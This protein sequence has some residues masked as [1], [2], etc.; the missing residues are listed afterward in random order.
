MFLYNRCF[1]D[2]AFFKK[3]LGDV[4]VVLRSIIVDVFI[5][6]VHRSPLSLSV[7]LEHSVTLLHLIFFSLA[8]SSFVFSREVSYKLCKSGS[9]AH[10]HPSAERRQRSPCGELN[11]PWPLRTQRSQ[12]SR[13]S[14]LHLSHR[15]RHN[16]SLSPLSRLRRMQRCLEERRERRPP[17]RRNSR[18]LEPQP[19]GGTAKKWQ[20]CL[21]KIH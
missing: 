11:E 17:L 19:R 9:S 6:P 14:S 21:S 10:T 13:G 5:S 4:R 8:A 1:P 2:E 7:S 12:C 16:L 18:G 20:M 3:H 15:L